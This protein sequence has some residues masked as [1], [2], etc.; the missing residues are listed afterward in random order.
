MIDISSFVGNGEK[1]H[2]QF[3]KVK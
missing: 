3:Y 1:V 2:C